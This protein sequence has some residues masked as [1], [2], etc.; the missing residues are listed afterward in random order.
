MSNDGRDAGQASKAN[1]LNR[2]N[3]LLAGTTLAAATALNASGPIKS[4]QAQAAGKPNIL[5]I[6]ATTSASP[7]SA[8]TRRD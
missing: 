7:T 8:P 4:A 2:R 1:A 5:V 3:I 6:F